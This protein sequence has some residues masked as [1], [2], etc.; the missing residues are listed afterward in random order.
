[1]RRLAI[2]TTALLALGGCK[3][4]LSKEKGEL[5]DAV[6]FALYNIEENSKGRTGEQSPLQRQIVDQSIEFWRIGRNGIGTS[7]D[8]INQKIQNSAYV[9]YKWIISSPEPCVFRK[10]E[11]TEFSQGKSQEDF[12]AYTMGG[13]GSDGVVDLNKASRFV[14][15]SE[16]PLTQIAI[17]G[18]AVHCVA[19]GW[20]ENYFNTTV[21][22]DGYTPRG[23][24]PYVVQ[25]KEK[26]IDLIKKACPGKAY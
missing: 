21:D 10:R 8:E 17:T 2:L 3:Q 12:S 23:E 7:S 11:F 18:P 19:D 6:M 22:I 9:R 24:K 14:L 20:C 26:A 1:M 16:P 5:M 15:L 13:I 4:E 25:R